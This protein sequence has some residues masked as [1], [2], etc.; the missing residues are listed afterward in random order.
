MAS[1][2]TSAGGSG[3]STGGGTVV[4]SKYLAVTDGDGGCVINPEASLVCWGWV[5]DAAP[6]AGAFGSVSSFSDDDVICA[7]DSMSV[8]HCWSAITSIEANP[9][10]V[11]QV[12]VGRNYACAISQADQLASCWQTAVTDPLPVLEP[13][14]T[15]FTI[16]GTGYFHACGI[17]VDGTL[18]CW[19]EETLERLNAPA[20]S[21]ESVAAGTFHTCAVATSGEI[22]C[23]GGSP[24]T[25][26]DEPPSG[27][28]ID[29]SVAD[30]YS[31][32]ILSDGSISCWG[33]FPEGAPS[34]QFRQIAAVNDYAC[35]VSIDG[36][37]TCWGELGPMTTPPEGIIV[38]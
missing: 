29:I 8:P 37:L 11:L 6:T 36:A 16:V 27:S 26:R 7:L 19:G 34:G 3:G 31:C 12:A 24:G 30:E 20:G 4:E 5:A 21:F 17:L 33:L 14:Q 38:K 2:P 18:S 9:S 32:G 15:P 22:S 10:A 13:P 25:G 1:S 35:A 28:F 23:W